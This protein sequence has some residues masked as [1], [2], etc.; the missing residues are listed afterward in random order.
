MSLSVRPIVSCGSGI[1]ITGLFTLGAVLALSGTVFAASPPSGSAPSAG[2]VLSSWGPWVEESVPFFSSVVDASASGF[3]SPENNL[4]PRGLILNLGQDVWACFDTDLLRVSAVWQGKSVTMSALAPVSYLDPAKKTNEGQD[5]LPHPDGRVWLANGIYPGWQ[6]GEHPTVTDPRE[7][8][9]TPAEV[10]RGPLAPELARFE[11]VRLSPEGVVLEYTVAGARVAEQMRSGKHEGV[12]ERHFQ[13]APSDKAVVLVLGQKSK[14]SATSRELNVSIAGSGMASV[15][16]LKEPEVWAVK[17]LPHTHPIEF[18]VAFTFGAAAEPGSLARNQTKPPQVRWPQVLRTKVGKSKLTDAYV[19]DDVPLPLNNPWKRN[20][21]PTSLDFFQDGRAA[22]GTLDG[23][24]WIINGLAK[25]DGELEWKRFASGLHEPMSIAVRNDEIFVYDRN[26]IWRLKDSHNS[27]EADVHE[28]FSNCFAQTAETRE[29]PES[30]KLAPDG[31][32]VISKGGQQGVNLGKK[33]TISGHLGKD[34]GKVLRISAD[35][36]KSTELG[37]G[38][39]G[40]FIGVH[41]KT[42]VVTV[43][44]Q[45]GNYVPTTPLY[46]LGATSEYHGH[47]NASRPKEKYP[48]PIADPLTWIPHPVNASA[49]T[50]AWLVGAKM[51][52]LNDGLIHFG[53]TRPEIF[54]VL[55]NT[56]S[57]KPQAA[58]V[59]LSHAIEFPPLNGA[60]NPVD[61]Q[62]YMAGFVGWGTT[63]VRNSGMARLRYTGAPHHLPKEVVPMDKGVLLRFD[64]E[65]DPERISDSAN[66]SVERWN[67]VRTFKYGSPHVKLDGK[68]GQDWMQIGGVYLSKD[69]KSIFIGIPDMKPVMQMRVGWSISSVAKNR[70]DDNAYFTPYELSRFDPDAEGFGKLEVDLTP[71]TVTAKAVVAASVEEGARLYNFFGCAACHSTDGSM[72]GKIGPTWKGL[73]GSKRQFA[74]KTAAIADE[75]YI[76]E[77]IVDPS[78]KVVAGYEKSESGMPNYNGVL[79]ESQIESLTLFIKSLR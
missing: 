24:V 29:F 62:L 1:R 55:L 57:T 17:V 10:G 25:A 46:L 21:R 60:V 42:G 4:T 68:P 59:S 61:G 3:A 49:V 70:L 30:M 15:S 67:Y 65:L 39:R 77:S 36:L 72:I 34:N 2:S 37:W 20:V 43:S 6:L 9:P 11:A 58:V 5:K 38:F 76:H 14:D 64:V 71:K 33:G 63:A 45:E 41:P 7:P 13:M 75:A 78:A 54:Q 22:L 19:L 44:D 53:Y 28:L 48:A 40:P 27:G 51:G 18:A 79:T 31:S 73:F 52:P 69:S 47:L 23:D 50:Q 12:V 35:G 66:F 8:A 56:R 74:D 16:L 26:G 32:F